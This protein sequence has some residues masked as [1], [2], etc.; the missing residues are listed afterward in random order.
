MNWQP[1]KSLTGALVLT[2]A[3]TLPTLAADEALVELIP[4]ES[5]AVLH[6]KD[7]SELPARLE[8]SPLGKLWQ[9]AKFQKFI[10]P[11][12]K[13]L[14]EEAL[15][16]P[17]AKA[18]METIKDALNNFQGESVV[19][20]IRLPIEAIMEEAE[21][22]G[23]DDDD[24]AVKD[25]RARAMEKDLRAVAMGKVDAGSTGFLD[26][27][28]DLVEQIIAQEEK[29]D[30]GDNAELITEKVDGQDLHMLRLTH[31]EVKK[32]FDTL[33]FAQVGDVGI[34]GFPRQSVEE[35]LANL[36]KG[37]KGDNITTSSFGDYHKRTPDND[38]H[39]HLNLEP[40]M[41]LALDAASKAEEAGM[42]GPQAAG[43][44]ITVQGIYDAL[45]LGD[46]RSLN[47]S[48]QFDGDANILGTALQFT[49][50]SGL[51]NL[52]AYQNGKLPKADFIPE[53]I[54]S[55]SVGLFSF[56]AMY[57]EIL[58]MA[59]K[60]SPAMAPMIKQQL[61][62]FEGQLGVSLEKDLFGNLNDNLI[63][64][65]SASFG[66]EGEDLAQDDM[67][68]MLGLKDKKGFE[69]A[70]DKVLAFVS[71]MTGFAFEPSE[72]LGH[73]MH[74]FEAPGMGPGGAA[75]K[76]S[77]LMTDGYFLVSIGKGETLRKVLS[78][79]K[80]PGKSLW[81]KPGVKQALPRLGENLVDISYADL[82][83]LASGACD[84]LSQF[85]T[86]EDSP[87]DWDNAPTAQEWQAL[88]GFIISGTQL[89]K[90]GFF[91][92]AIML[93]NE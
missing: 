68:L 42:L 37:L 5:L 27:W 61:T 53:N 44:G 71:G 93:P 32:P 77:Y 6:V 88:L 21:N 92:K 64:L 40:M 82:G 36:Q 74:S 59:E 18:A 10:A 17:S 2:S 50:R 62:A 9:D 58:T 46:L 43:M 80:R 52:V 28:R 86:G 87:V 49:K 14:N 45:G 73:Q 29:K 48:M 34:V 30:D 3:F 26:T 19:A 12:M 38:V 76:I 84:T 33:T 24:P 83:A 79:L 69:V 91:G 81:D 57:Q 16:D 7:A 8:E 41:A 85:I 72:F 15:D 56:G 75:T 66:G 11:A 51:M 70:F 54:G 20:L 23:G 35:G 47:M 78:N 65:Q 39:L 55:A 60:I 63:S 4:A 31:P 67:V 13:E 89:E 22:G 1:L 25:R 90:N